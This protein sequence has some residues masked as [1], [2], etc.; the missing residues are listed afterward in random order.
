L[1]ITPEKLKSSALLAARLEQAAEKPNSVT[2]AAK[3]FTNSRAFT[4]ALKSA[5]PPK[6]TVSPQPA[7]AWSPVFCH[8]EK[9]D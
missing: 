1:P 6:T 8:Q 2:S 3:A 5:A 7:S 4:A 9:R